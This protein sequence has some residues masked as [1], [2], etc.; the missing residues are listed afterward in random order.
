MP[1]GRV[2][3]L[4]MGKLGSR[5]MTAASDLDLIVIYDFPEAR[6]SRTAG[7]RWAP[8]LYYARLTQRL[9]A[10][11]TAPTKAGK[12]YE[13]DLRLRP[14][15]RKGPLATSLERLRALSARGGGDLGAHGADARARR[16]RRRGLAREIALVRRRRSAS[17]ASPRKLAR[18]IRDMRALIA[19]EKGDKGPFDLKLAPGGLIDVEFIA[20]YL[21]LAHARAHP[22]DPASGDARG[23]G[24]GGARRLDF[25]R[26]RGGARR[27]ASAHDRRHADPALDLA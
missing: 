8:A 16:S 19:R 27:R 1:G 11:L 7:G 10:A 13:V 25:G 23:S 20:Q 22:D 12:L 9:V 2:A 18:D 6:R 14:S 17:R 26:G 21:M 5:E 24:G 4:A 3:V 15:G